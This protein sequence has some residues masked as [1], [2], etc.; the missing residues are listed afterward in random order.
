M[1]NFE[2]KDEYI[3]RV[4]E[5][6]SSIWEKITQECRDESKMGAV[7]MLSA[8]NYLFRINDVRWAVD[9]VYSAPNIPTPEYAADNLD[10]LDLALLTHAHSDHCDKEL[11][12]QLC[13]KKDFVLAVPAH[14]EEYALEKVDVINCDIR[15]VEPRDTICV[16]RLKA[17]AFNSCHFDFSGTVC[18]K[19]G[20]EET[21]W[22]VDVNDKTL[23]FPGDIRDYSVFEM[24]SDF[25]RIDWLFAHFWLG[26]HKAFTFEAKDVNAFVDF[27]GAFGAENVCLTHLLET[28]RAYS[29]PADYWTLEHAE[30]VMEVFLQ[31]FPKSS[32]T[33]LTTGERIDL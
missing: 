7:W 33:T 27:M 21:G 12:A 24:F 3:Y 10:F 13:R 20:C 8:A 5:Q 26:R 18:E 23:L 6:Y 31:R 30:I 17:T 29:A 1:K 2:S 25:G 15:I 14:M 28:S 19:N 9:P 4:N 11:I 22:L 16:G 32:I